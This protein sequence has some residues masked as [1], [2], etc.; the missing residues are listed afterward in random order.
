MTNNATFF[1]RPKN[2]FVISALIVLLAG[3]M[4]WVHGQDITNL[5]VNSAIGTINTTN[6]CPIP[7]YSAIYSTIQAAV[8]CAQNGDTLDIAAGTYNENVVISKNLTI[9][10]TSAADSI[11]NANGNGNTVTIATGIAVRLS[12]LTITGGN[13]DLGGGIFTTEGNIEIT[14]S[15]ITNNKATTAGGGIYSRAGTIKLVNSTISNNQPAGEGGGIFTR[16]GTV[17]IQNSTISGHVVNGQGGGVRSAAGTV[18][19]TNTTVSG[20]TANLGGGI[21]SEAGTVTLGNVTVADNSSGVVSTQATI[22]VGNS[23]LASNNNVPCA[24]TLISTGNNITATLPSNCT[25]TGDNTGNITS[26]DAKLGVL[27]ANG[28]T[29]QTQALL[30]GSPALDAGNGCESID[31][32]G[33]VRPQGSGCDSGAYEGIRG[34]CNADLIVN[35]GDVTALTS[36]IFDKDGGTPVNVPAGTFTGDSIGCNSNADQVV[37]AGDLACL[38]LIINDFAAV[39]EKKT[40]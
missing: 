27:K 10:G 21:E 5:V 12:N 22:K 25:L 15:I 20:N 31:Q 6:P 8:A 40:P 2:I 17:S 28:G 3:T 34:D 29:T 38:S 39:C 30:D 24:G 19:M 32:R 1:G 14:D 26:V 18:H 37:D 16:A 11:I 23:I 35:N 7:R 36:E 9:N 13:A 4:A 33:A